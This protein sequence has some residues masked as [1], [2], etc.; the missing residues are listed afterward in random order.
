MSLVR[1]EPLRASAGPC[2]RRRTSFP[3]P[4]TVFDL[5]NGLLRFSSVSAV[6]YAPRVALSVST[7]PTIRTLSSTGFAGSA[8]KNRKRP[9]W[10]RLL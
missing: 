8:L 2:G 6:K 4:G 3:P 7:W 5:P 9:T 1:G 10:R